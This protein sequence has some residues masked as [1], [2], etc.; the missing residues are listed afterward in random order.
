MRFLMMHVNSFASGVEGGIRDP[1]RSDLTISLARSLR[2][3]LLLPNEKKFNNLEQD[4]SRIQSSIRDEQEKMAV[5]IGDRFSRM[6]S[7]LAMLTKTTRITALLLLA[8]LAG[9]ITILVMLL[10]WY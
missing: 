8:T 9:I 10:S 2:D 6:E 5:E 7:E 4:L 1:D 3:G